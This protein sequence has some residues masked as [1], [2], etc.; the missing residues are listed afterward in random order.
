[1]KKLL[2][3]LTALVLLLAFAALAEET[4]TSGDFEYRLLTNGEAE[5]T[6]Y[7]GKADKLDIPSVLDG[8]KV[9]VIGDWAFTNCDSLI[10]VTI[11]GSVTSI[12]ANPF[13]GC[14]KLTTLKV[15][16]ESEYLAVIDGVLFSKPDR[17]LVCCPRAFTQ[18]EYSIPKGI[19]II[20]DSAF[21]YCRSLTSVTIPESI[22]NIDRSAFAK[23]DRLTSVTIPGS[24]TSIGGYAFVYC[25][26]LASVTI[27]ASVTSIGS[28]AFSHCGEQLVITV[29]KGSCAADYCKENGLTYQYTDA[30][31]WLKN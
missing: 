5:I 11:P 14:R 23:C 20:G 1:M 25:E 16:P 2:A 19:R 27:P 6:K 18:A 29:D 12:G 10:S 13:C 30:L 3:V 28:Y 26:S 15:S 21:A 22:T 8:H 31:D 9:T 4:L 7:D 24:V 17:R